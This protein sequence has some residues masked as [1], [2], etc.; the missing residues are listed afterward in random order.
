MRDRHGVCVCV[1]SDACLCFRISFSQ[2][3]VIFRM[4]VNEL[5][6][7]LCDIISCSSRLVAEIWMFSDV[8]TKYKRSLTLTTEILQ[9]N[10]TS[11]P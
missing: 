3:G 1:S 6:L 8:D 9:N 11:N 10:C 4:K 7:L 5:E 2:C